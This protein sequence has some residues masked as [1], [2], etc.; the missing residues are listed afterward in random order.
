MEASAALARSS[1]SH[2]SKATMRSHRRTSTLKRST[3][4]RL[5]A[6]AVSARSTRGAGFEVRVEASYAVAFSEVL[7]ELLGGVVA[8][9]HR[10]ST[11]PA[12]RFQ[13]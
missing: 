12:Q 3:S 1:R 11:H 10:V 2:Y 9:D 4:E 7:S 5:Q 6:D 13:T 8:I